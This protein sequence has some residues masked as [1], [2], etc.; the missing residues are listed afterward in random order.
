MPSGRVH[1]KLWQSGIKP[2]LFFWLFLLVISSLLTLPWRLAAIFYFPG[3]LAGILLDPDLDMTNRVAVRKRWERTIILF[4]FTYWWLI[5]AKMNKH[6]SFISHFPYV[7]TLIRMIWIGIP[8]TGILAL[9]GLLELII[10]NMDMVGPILIGFW[11]GLA[12]ADKI[13]Y[14]LDNGFGGYYG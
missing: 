1:L 9:F 6:R 3:Y 7:S 4:P 10:T 5:Y 11:L 2:A 8:I 13:H 14:T 12:E